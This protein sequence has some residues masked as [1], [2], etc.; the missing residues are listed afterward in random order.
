M[1]DYEWLTSM[2]LCHKCRKKKPAP[3]RK[4]CFDCLDIIR[5]DDRKRYNAEKSKE[6]QCRRREIYQEKKAAGICVR[7]S[8]PATH[9][10]YC[11]EH[12]IEQKRASQKRSQIRKIARHER[13]LIP[14]E[15][16]SKSLCLWCGNPVVPGLQCCEKHREVFIN[17]GKKEKEKDKVVN[18]F[19]KLRKSKNSEN[20]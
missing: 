13:E 4:F 1:T 5:A 6:Y 16:K 14:D 19:W 17:A 12:S 18:G 8:K 9:G 2:N 11:Y 15:R 20:F 3:G 10:M 7:C